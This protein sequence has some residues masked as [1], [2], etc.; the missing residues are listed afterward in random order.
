MTYQIFDKWVRS[1][2]SFLATDL[3]AFVQKMFIGSQIFQ[4][5]GNNYNQD[6][7]KIKHVIRKWKCSEDVTEM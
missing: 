5:E 4:T 6:I 1:I 2:N 7:W 3:L